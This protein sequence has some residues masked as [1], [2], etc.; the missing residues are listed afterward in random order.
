MK[1]HI[2]SKGNIRVLKIISRTLL[3]FFLFGFGYKVIP[4]NPYGVFILGKD[5]SQVIIF[6]FLFSAMVLEITF[7]CLEKKRGFSVKKSEVNFWKVLV[8]VLLIAVALFIVSLFGHCF[9]E[10]Q[11]SRIISAIGQARTVMSYLQYTEGHYDNFTCQHLEMVDLCNRIDRMYQPRFSEIP[12]FSIRKQKDYLED[13]KEPIIARNALSQSQAVCIYAPLNF[14][15][16]YCAD[17]TTGRAGF[18]DV[19]P[20]SEGYCVE[21]ESAVCPSVSG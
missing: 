6:L 2:E 17:S 18:T 13:S 8:P 20:G 10:P 16:W 21:G 5:I 1:I 4:C 7:F 3:V 9:V 11:D 14:R 12:F 15:D 19:D